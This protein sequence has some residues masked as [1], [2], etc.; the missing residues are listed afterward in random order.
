MADIRVTS[1]ELRSVSAQLSTGACDIESRLAQLHGQVQALIAQGW[2][3]SASVAF[4]ELFQQWNVSGT[5]LKQA[6]D[7]IAQQLA[8]TATTYEQTEAQLTAAL[9]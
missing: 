3:G 9:R 2:Q 6:L 7:G 1:A 8:N 5:A 4:G